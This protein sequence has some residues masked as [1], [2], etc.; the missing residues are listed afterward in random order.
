MPNK[1]KSQP[2]RGTASPHQRGHV[3]GFFARLRAYFFAGVLVTAPLFITVYLAW[4][5]ITFIDQQVAGIVPE[6]VRPY[7]PFGVPGVGVLIVAAA[8]VFIGWFTAGFLGRMIVTAQDRLLT[9]TPVVRNVYSALKQI[10]ETVMAHKSSAFREVVLLEY[11]R[12]GIWAMGFITGTTEGEVQHLTEDPVVN[13]FGPTTPNPTSGFLLFVPRADLVVLDMSV[14]EGI[15][16]VVS[17]GIVTPPDRR[18]A[19]E[20]E[21]PAVSTR[22]RGAG[23]AIEEWADEVAL[24]DANTRTQPHQGRLA[25]PSKPGR[26]P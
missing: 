6:T 19:I 1:S 21:V 12:R 3:L 5:I 7:L 4:L 25:G 26:D 23:K 17:G 11:P 20:Q 9:R 15:K 8:L 13:I 16:M 18:P 2:R 14:E 10:F 22:M 24:R